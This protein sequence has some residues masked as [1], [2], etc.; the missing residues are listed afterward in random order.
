[1]IDLERLRFR[2]DR[3]ECFGLAATAEIQGGRVF[4]KALTHHV[5]VSEQVLPRIHRAA[6]N[7]AEKLGVTN[8]LVVFVYSG[9]DPGASCTQEKD[10]PRVFVF[11]SAALV[12][13]LS[14]GELEFILGHELGHLLF[15]HLRYPKQE[16]GENLRHLELNRAAEI[17]ADR[18]G[19]IAAP[20]LAA[21]L[22][23]TLKVASGLDESN[24]EL[25]VDAYTRQARELAETVGDETILMSTHPPFPLRARA[26][27]G[28]EPILAGLRAGRSGADELERLD[29]RVR[30]EFEAAASGAAGNRFTEMAKSAAFWTVAQEACAGGRYPIAAQEA[31]RRHFGDERVDALRQLLGEQGKDAGVTL[32]RERAESTRQSLKQAPTLA[33]RIYDEFVRGYPKA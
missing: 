30:A 24:L 22:R 8:P 1:M 7:A 4:G 14:D 21:A 5:R 19:L 3:P 27:Q 17:S 15:G 20:S 18:A 10:D 33:E 12:R 29:E 26:L 6:R 16:G 2:F 25:D 11:V 9:S 32:L 28:F 23:A 13:L 31:M